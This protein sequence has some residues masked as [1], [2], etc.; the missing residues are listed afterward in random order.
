ML[1]LEGGLGGHMNHLYDNREL[2]FAKMKEIIH[3]AANGKLQVAEKTDGQNLFISYSIPEGKA[4]SARNKGNI[5]SG[6]MDAAELASKFSGR[7]GL[8]DAFT[9]SFAAFE[10]VIKKMPVE[11][12]RKIFGDNADIFYNAEVMDPRSANVINYDRKYLLIHREGHAK[13]DRNTGEIED[14][15]VSDNAAVLEKALKQYAET[16]DTY[17]VM[18]KTLRPIEAISNKE[19]LNNTIERLN[20]FMNKHQLSD[21]DTVGDY[22]VNSLTFEIQKLN[23]KFVNKLSEQ[24]INTLVRKMLGDKGIK[25]VEVYKNLQPQDKEAIK[26]LVDNAD[27][28]LK[29]LIFPLED[30][31][32]DFAVEVLKGMKSLYVLDNSKEVQRLKDEVSNAL[33]QIKASGNQQEYDFIEKQLRKLKSLENINTP[34]EGIVFQYDGNLFK[35][36]GNFAPINQLLGFFKYG[37]S[38]KLKENQEINSNSQKAVYF[39]FGRM[40]P[41][42]L[43]H[44]IML[45]EGLQ[46]AKKNNSDFK[47][48]LSKT[49]DNKKNP[50][51]YVTKVELF[52][53]MF[54]QF[55]QYLV[56]DP[57][58]K[59][60]VEVL[61]SLSGKY[62]K[63]VMLVGEDRV[64]EFQNLLTQYNNIEYAFDEIVVQNTGGRVSGRSATAMRAFVSK[65]DLQGFISAYKEAFPNLDTQTIEEMYNAIDAGF[66]S[67]PPKRKKKKIGLEEILQI[68]SEMSA[69]SA[70]SAE[71]GVGIAKDTLFKTKK[72]KKGT[73][74]MKET[75][76][77]EAQLRQ[78]IRNAIRLHKMNKLQEFKKSKLEEQQ[79]RFILRKLIMEV[80][81]DQPI[82][83]NTGINV[84]EDLLKKIIPVIQTDYKIMTTSETQRLSF[85]AHILNAIQ[86]SLKP[87][88]YRKEEPPPGAPLQEKKVKIDL[89]D[90][91]MELDKSKFIDVFDT[92]KKK[93]EEDEKLKTPESRLSTGLEDK[94]LD[95]TGRNM[96]LQTFR[97]IDNSVMDAYT[98]LDDSKDKDLFYDY[99]ITNLK[100]YFDKFE[101]E[102]MDMPKTEPT[103]PEYQAEKE[104][105]EEEDAPVEA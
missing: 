26:S 6:G 98:I 57:N 59:T 80:G 44:G 58:I 65:G 101:E 36:T 41:P 104:K 76:E 14:I 93:A 64:S 47:I 62:S 5:K 68:I 48:Y 85:R 25:V 87:E 50:L 102:M 97:K 28:L 75:N 42:T 88:L 53:K 61:G 34:V 71:V 7:G 18:M 84:L 32:H 70:G 90:S 69:M 52:K 29:K 91:D 17:N 60:A 30:I 72:K 77:D 67:E 66:K 82:H 22:I 12:Q 3:D 37:R 45:Q 51:P 78:V 2:S 19:V 100:L 15:D 39:V 21:D 96:A 31:I 89:E 56:E 23:N 46:M 94:K 79:L 105:K 9:D 4:K 43:G 99:L 55:A 92:E 74:I 63:A 40:N 38:E 20:Q 49:S 86:N 81:D 8:Y 83:D 13:F 103:T 33:N 35:L 16:N 54:P 11:L 27:D 95:S 1:L 10:T 73:T 24:E